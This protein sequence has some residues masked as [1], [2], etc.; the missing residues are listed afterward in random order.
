MDE[1]CYSES[2]SIREILEKP[3]KELPWSPLLHFHPNEIDQMPD[4]LRGVYLI[5]YQDNPKELKPASMLY[6]GCDDHCLKCSLSDQYLGKG[7]VFLPDFVRANPS[8]IFFQYLCCQDCKR[9]EAYLLVA[10]SYPLCN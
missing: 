6:V 1:G 5:R 4:L 8:G 9:A 7:N 2:V 3:L 10:L